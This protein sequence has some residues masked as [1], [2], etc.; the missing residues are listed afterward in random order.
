MVRGYF[1]RSGEKKYRELEAKNP[2]YEANVWI[3][4]STYIGGDSPEATQQKKE[5]E[6]FKEWAKTNQINII[7]INPNAT[8][9]D[10][11]VNKRPELFKGMNSA[12][13]YLD[14]LKDPGSNYAA[15]SD[16]LRAEVLYHVGDVYFDA[17]DVLPRMPL[18]QLNTQKGIM[19]RIFGG[20]DNINNDIIASIS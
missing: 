5:Y 20:N 17:E 1:K 9:P 13:Y 18:N 15:A 10:P 2:D 12:Q 19:F 7:D 4:S 6:Q 11:A 14:E 16:I 3:D 8:D